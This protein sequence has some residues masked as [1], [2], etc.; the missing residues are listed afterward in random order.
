[1]NYQHTRWECHILQSSQE[2][3]TLHYLKSM[4]LMTQSQAAL[5]LHPFHAA[6]NNKYLTCGVFLCQITIF[7]REK[8]PFRVMLL[9]KRDTVTVSACDFNIYSRESAHLS[10]RRRVPHFRCQ[11]FT[12]NAT[13]P[14][15]IKMFQTEVYINKCLLVYFPF[16]FN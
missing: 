8:K 5:F 1:M 10:N 16:K 15:T 11:N 2:S 6:D 9:T 4:K 12:R 3:P 13:R 7:I 14:F